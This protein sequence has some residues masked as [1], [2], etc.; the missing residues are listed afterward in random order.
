M[1]QPDPKNID[2]QVGMPSSPKP[3]VVDPVVDPNVSRELSEPPLGDGSVTV[4]GDVVDS[5][6]VTGD[7][8]NVVGTLIVGSDAGVQELDVRFEQKVAG[9]YVVTSNIGDERRPTVSTF[10]SPFSELELIGA[11]AARWRGELNADAHAY[12]ERLFRAL[13]TPPLMEL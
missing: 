9:E 2:S 7:Q 1:N 6:I 10:R 4:S 11:R 13:F 8:N 3:L 12:G 5:I